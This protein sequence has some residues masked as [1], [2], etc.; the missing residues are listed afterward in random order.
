MSD[1][2]KHLRLA[3]DV[4]RK[5]GAA[6]DKLQRALEDRHRSASPALIAASC[7]G[8]SPA[9]AAPR[10]AP[11]S[12]G[13]KTTAHG[14][15]AWSSSA[16]L[17]FSSSR[18]GDP[19]LLE[20]SYAAFRQASVSPGRKPTHDRGG[21]A[22]SSSTLPL[23][24]SFPDG[25]GDPVLESS[26]AALRH[27]PRSPEFK[28][29]HGA[30]PTGDGWVFSQEAQSSHRTP[31]ERV[32]SPIAF[33]QDGA[34]SAS[35]ACSAPF[36]GRTTDL[37][38]AGSR[39]PE[40]TPGLVHCSPATPSECRS[41]PVPERPPVPR[42]RIITPSPHREEAATVPYCTTASSETASGLPGS[43]PP[44]WPYPDGVPNGNAGVAVASMRVPAEGCR[45]VRPS[46]SPPSRRSVLTPDGPGTFSRQSAGFAEQ[47]PAD[48]DHSAHPAARSDQRPEAFPSS[49]TDRR[50]P[51]GPAAGSRDLV[52]GLDYSSPRGSVPAGTQGHPSISSGQVSVIEAGNNNTMLPSTPTVGTTSPL[53]PE[54]R[55]T[56]TRCRTLDVTEGHEPS[57]VHPPGPAQGDGDGLGVL[58][59]FGEGAN[60]GQ[61]DQQD[62][63]ELARGDGWTCK[64]S[65]VDYDLACSPQSGLPPMHQPMRDD[66]PPQRACPASDGGGRFVDS[67]CV[68]S[69]EGNAGLHWAAAAGSLNVSRISSAG[70]DRQQHHNSSLEEYKAGLDGVRH[71]P[72]VAQQL[73]AASRASTAEGREL[74]LV[75]LSGAPER[76]TAQT[77]GAVHSRQRDSPRRAGNR[78][79][80]RDASAPAEQGELREAT[81]PAAG[82]REQFD[83]SP[84]PAEQGE[85][86]EVASR[87]GKREATSVEGVPRC[88]EHEAAGSPP[89][90]SPVRSRPDQAGDE[91]VTPRRRTA[92][93]RA[94]DAPGRGAPAA[95]QADSP[96]IRSVVSSPSRGEERVATALRGSSQYSAVPLGS[97]SPEGCGEDQ[98]AVRKSPGRGVGLNEFEGLFATDA[99]GT[100]SVETGLQYRGDRQLD[101]KFFGGPAP[102]TTEDGAALGYPG[103]R[104]L[105]A[106]FLA[107]TEDGAALG[108]LGYPGDRQLDAKFF[109][110]AVPAAGAGLGY[111]RN[112]ESGD[113]F[114][115]AAGSVATDAAPGCRGGER[116]L[117]DKFFASSG[118]TLSASGVRRS[119]PMALSDLLRNDASAE[120]CFGAG[121]ADEPATDDGFAGKRGETT[122][123]VSPSA[124]AW[125]GRPGAAAAAAGRDDELF[126]RLLSAADAFEGSPGVPGERL[127]REA[128][129]RTA[130]KE[131]GKKR[132]TDRRRADVR[133]V[134]GKGAGAPLRAK[135]QE[136]GDGSGTDVVLVLTLEID[137]ERSVS[138]VLHA[139]DDA[140]EA[141]RECV[142]QH[143]LPACLVPVLA[144]RIEGMLASQKQHG[145]QET[146]RTARARTASRTPSP[147]LSNGRQPVLKP[148]AAAAAAP[149]ASFSRR[150][151]PTVSPSRRQVAGVG[152]SFGRRAPR[153]VSPVRSLPAPPAAARGRGP[154]T[155]ITRSASNASN[156]PP[157]KPLKADAGLRLYRQAVKEPKVPLQAG[158]KTEVDGGGAVCAMHFR[159]A[160]L[161]SVKAHCAVDERRRPGFPGTV[162][163]RRAAEAAV[164][165]AR[166]RSL[167]PYALKLAGVR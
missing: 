68:D 131:A 151:V 114:F 137:A 149:S 101:A 111:R 107:T 41:D 128:G 32:V 161:S 106:Q 129:G 20:S 74:L 78:E 34:R 166:G 121:L 70:D 4:F 112:G 103:D 84:A 157:Q 94:A 8:G 96:G 86:D 105:D 139:G 62:D 9:G 17:P 50:T 135:K 92:R 91:E 10:Q 46:E 147:R 73:H 71:D 38:L 25:G 51:E 81:R 163:G 102:A 156:R 127:A 53:T 119:A 138:V 155:C 141:A 140:T 56:R 104:Q 44:H 124:A 123:C 154:L 47:A 80:F 26:H 146:R 117:E 122:V 33:P 98:P 100:R 144:V 19:V 28:A 24:S 22:W 83:E 39:S 3:R 136:V 97:Q 109:A 116:E 108:A 130:A 115:A 67:R 143:G 12:P 110:G 113:K 14:G 48:G 66:A 145:T 59:L 42:R 64:S 75:D 79:Q 29:Q 21:L 18:P 142:E 93:S 69:A 165:R 167:A 2:E 13:R 43:D 164:H 88:P 132:E 54:R 36:Q 15:L 60:A 87:R 57:S 95:G 90:R 40:Q 7:G 125:D 152:V 55:A 63:S 148:A 89:A 134:G 30:R 6:E 72:A 99:A 16:P 85:F 65:I 118:D 37:L 162:H 150:R 160:A 76:G 58:D 153:S 1:L 52:R 31:G 11:G 35:E 23:F 5:I 159:A 82:H 133:P 45:S 158:A 61:D 126:A 27:A 49:D 77:A 120:S